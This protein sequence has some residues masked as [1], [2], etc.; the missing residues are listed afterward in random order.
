MAQTVRIRTTAKQM[1]ARPE[2]RP[3][4]TPLEDAVTIVLAT[5]TLFAV[6]WDGLLHNN[7]GELDSFWSS[8]HIGMYAGL[9]TLGAWIGLIFL[10]YQPKGRLELSLAAVPRGYGLALVALPLAAL[11]GPGDFI[12]HAIYGFENQ[13]DAPFSPTHQMLFL[14]GALLG[15]IPL[16][17]IWW[18]SGRAPR[19]G[20]LWPAVLSMT[21]VVAMINFTFMN[22][23]PFFW[24]IVPTEAFQ[25]DLLRYDDAYAP[26]ADIVH[27][28][29]LGEAAERLGDGAFPYYLFSNMQVIAGILIFSAVIVAAVLYLRRRWV[30]PFGSLTL[31][32]SLLAVLFPFFTAFRH[33]EFI[34]ALVAAGIGADLLARWLVSGD[35]P[36]TLRL[37]AFGTLLPPVVWACYL[38]T[39]ELAS[40]LGWN[41]TVWNGVISTTAGVGYGISLI[42][43]PPALPQPPAVE[44]A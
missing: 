14:S 37:R 12:W 39:I 7:T 24:V 29:G 25:N 11:G 31:M 15:A 19:L 32:F 44:G 1:L 16:G 6:F 20:E 21:A 42:V 4:T 36:S 22:L 8:A 33:P 34:A 27:P 26:G 43:F 3:Q 10:R 40:G 18:R 30:L 35:P 5:L 13:V 38:L 2:V 23:L 28:E 41:P 17:S 9:T